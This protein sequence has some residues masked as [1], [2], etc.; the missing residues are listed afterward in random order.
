MIPIAA[1]HSISATRVVLPFWHVVGNEP[2]EHVSGLYA[3][4]TIRQFTEDIEFFA[5]NYQPIGLDDLTD[6]ITKGVLLPRRCFLPTFDDG[7]REVHDL[8]APILRSKG[9]PA[10]FFL[11]SSALDNRNLCYPQKKSLLLRAL[12]RCTDPVTLNEVSRLL[13]TAG[14]SGN[15][16]ADQ[17]RRIHYRQRHILEGLA[18]LLGCD[19][20]GYL[21]ARRPY[22]DSNQVLSLVRQ[23][24]AIGAHSVDHCYYPELQLDQQIDQTLRSRDEIAAHYPCDCTSFAFPYTDEGI[25]P[26]FFQTVFDLGKIQLT[27]GTGG[28]GRPRPPRHFPRFTMERTSLPAE[29]I[30]A[31]R[32]AKALFR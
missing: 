13:A 16:A 18:T 21:A 3:F 30:V 31:K 17:I 32:Y 10:V 29:R 26:V 23:G 27:F 11:V 19:F 28:I 20:N 14:I 9:V 5:R 12:A 15:L 4:R 2:I 24:F 22:L 25:S 7:F 1:L 6:S 8:I